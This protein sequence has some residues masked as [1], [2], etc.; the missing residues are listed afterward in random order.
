MPEFLKLK[1]S[2]C[3]NCYKC[4]RHCPVKSIKFSGD[5]AHIVSNECILCGQ[6]FV[7]CPQ[8][9][10]EIAND[11]ETNAIEKTIKLLIL[12]ILECFIPYVIPSVKASIL[13]DIA[14][15]IQ[16]IIKNRILSDN[17]IDSLSYII[18]SIIRENVTN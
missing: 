9:A 15:N 3:K 12:V 2:D 14:S 11:V 8:N 5:Q 13:T 1:K 18:I 16:L 6:C 4:I 17:Q 7:V 10:K